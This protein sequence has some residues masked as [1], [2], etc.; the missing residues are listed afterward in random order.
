M[1]PRYASHC[2]YT[3]NEDGKCRDIQNVGKCTN[4]ARQYNNLSWDNLT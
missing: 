1:T 2:Q 3:N 4:Q